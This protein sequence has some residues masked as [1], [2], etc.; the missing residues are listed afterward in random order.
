MLMGLDP[1]EATPGLYV[2]QR[3]MELTGRYE[4]YMG[5]ESV[6]VTYKG[7]LLYLESETPFAKTS[8]PIIPD[9]LLMENTSFYTLVDGVKS[10]IVFDGKNLFVERYCYHKV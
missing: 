7:G 8:T 10:P 3:M 2:K 4:T 9:D 6:D 1:V 5:I